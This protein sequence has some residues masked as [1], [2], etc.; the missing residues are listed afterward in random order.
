MA[1]VHSARMA[2]VHSARVAAVHSARVAGV[3]SARVGRVHSARV[4]AVHSARVARR[5]LA[6][7]HASSS[8][9]PGPP[10]DGPALG[11]K[12]SPLGLVALVTP[13]SE[14][15]AAVRGSAGALAGRTALAL[16]LAA[17]ALLGLLRGTLRPLERMAQTADEIRAGDRGARMTPLLPGR[18]R[19]EAGRLA[20]A[21]DRMLD[22]LVSSEAEMR[23]FLTDASHELRTPITV[24]GGYADVLLGGAGEDPATRRR[25]LLAIRGEVDRMARL[26]TDLLML[27]RLDGRL[28]RL[29]MRREPV[30]LL[31]LL[32]D[33]AEQARLRAPNRTVT[34]AGPDGVCVVGDPDRLRQVFANLADNVLAHTCPAGRLEIEAAPDPDAHEVHVCV[35]DDGPPIPQK[36][37]PSIFH[38][39]VKGAGSSGSGLGLA[40]VHAIVEAHGGQVE[41]RTDGPG[42]RF[43]ITLPQLR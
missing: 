31:P 14:V 25:A 30:P 23:R 22:A 42:N 34:L 5:R 4:A 3:H 17:L 36:A 39:F 32:A 13:L 2:G 15:D 43:T 20:T 40:I 11:P 26:V 6:L 41:V 19:D 24:A 21:F 28:D 12:P 9:S 16:L 29:E 7:L 35:R 1:G 33:V 18:W 37:I 27:A 38:R 10:V 8:S